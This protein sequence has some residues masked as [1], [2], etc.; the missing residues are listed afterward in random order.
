MVTPLWVAT[1]ALVVVG[2]I[3]VAASSALGGIWPGGPIDPL[4]TGNILLGAAVGTSMV[5]GGIRSPLALAVVPVLVIVALVGIGVFGWLGP[6]V[7]I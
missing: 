4:I 3:L 6:G 1:A 5:G 7:R 2:T